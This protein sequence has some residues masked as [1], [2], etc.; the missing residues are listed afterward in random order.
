MI[1]DDSL[2]SNVSHKHKAL[3]TSPNLTL[4]LRYLVEAADDNEEPTIE[5]KATDLSERGLLGEA[6]TS[7][8]ALTE[9]QAIY[10]VLREVGDYTYASKEH[11]EVANPD[12][13]RAQKL[14]L[15]LDKL[16]EATS[17]LRPKDNPVM[18]KVDLF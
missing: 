9:G 6:V 7:N 12:A 11:Q 14:G 8:F 15:P 10:F 1:V 13:S 5:L 17:K 4:D 18:S 3:F 2:P 16:M